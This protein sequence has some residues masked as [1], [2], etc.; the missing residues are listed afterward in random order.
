[1][2]HAKKLILYVCIILFAVAAGLP[3]SGADR[4]GY[5]AFGDSIAAGYGLDSPSE[6]YPVLLAQELDLS[7]KSFAENGETST[8]LK[9]KIEGLSKKEKRA[10]SDAALIT[11]SIG[12]NDLIGEENRRVVLTEALISILSGDYTMSEEMEEIYRTLKENI[13][14]IVSAL[15]ALNPDAVIL[16]QTL[17][18]PYLIGEYTYLGY[19][20][21]DALDYYVQK[22]N[23]TYAQALEESGGF[24]IVDTAEQ[25]NGVAEYFYTTFD[26][27]PT[28]A[29][30]VA[31]AGILADAY[32]DVKAPGGPAPS[33]TT[34]TA[35]SGATPGMTAQDGSI[36]S[37]GMTGDSGDTG[38]LESEKPDTTGSVSLS[39]P[40][41]EETIAAAAQ[42]ESDSPESPDYS[43]IVL[44]ITAA[45]FFAAVL[46]L[47]LRG[48]K[49]RKRT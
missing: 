7:L 37:G 27:H 17:Y 19:N 42:P 1:M 8:E 25:M 31:I 30:H 21:G 2:K 14:S 35:D 43:G 33:E 29:G 49:R 47:F 9:E 18:N 6:A 4:N 12:G 36:L 32:R 28:A 46:F 44:I 15:R 5:A 26:F 20:I 41:G 22:V 24:V 10:V 16:L 11:I 45:I 38:M 23:E 39:V 40:Q 13:I 3:A 48:L 34:Q